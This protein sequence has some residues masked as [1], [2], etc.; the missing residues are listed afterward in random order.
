[1]Y[2]YIPV[3]YFFGV[4]IKPEDG[5]VLMHNIEENRESSNL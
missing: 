5:Q 1:M 4:F 2:A 3:W